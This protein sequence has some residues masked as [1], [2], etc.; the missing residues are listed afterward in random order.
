MFEVW[1][2]KMVREG[3]VSDN[4][5]SHSIHVVRGASLSQSG[6]GLSV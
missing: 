5:S 1:V 4:N 2:R 6:R 3:W